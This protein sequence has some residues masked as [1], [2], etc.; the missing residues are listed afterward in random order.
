MKRLSRIIYELL[1]LLGLGLFATVVTLVFSAQR[2]SLQQASYPG[3][4]PVPTTTPEPTALL[5]S[6][7]EDVPFYIPPN[8][9]RIIYLASSLETV[10]S[11]LL[12]P[13]GELEAKGVT[14]V[15]GFDGIKSMFDK[16]E[17]APE[18]II[19]HKSRLN[20]VDKDWIQKI[21]PTGVVMAGVN[22]SV[23]ELAALLGDERAAQDPNWPDP[24][25]VPYF[26]ILHMKSSIAVP[27]G[28]A[29]EQQRAKAGEAIS[30]S[31]GVTANR[32][33]NS[34]DVDTFL[35]FIRQKISGVK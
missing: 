1:G 17:T 5:P 8:G 34:T 13:A 16:E 9:E 25:N 18:A 32:I 33:R 11:D 26:S 19:L 14:L 22:V 27:C 12:I 29:E 35:S 10:G 2:E 15:Y 7:T 28:S 31:W 4:S 23:H 6:A 3:P 21:Y 20:E 24:V 30:C